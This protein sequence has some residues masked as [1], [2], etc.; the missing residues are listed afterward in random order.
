MCAFHCQFS[1]PKILWS[2]NVPI[3]K[4]HSAYFLEASDFEY[5]Y[6]LLPSNYFSS[7]STYLS[8]ICSFCNAHFLKIPRILWHSNAKQSS[9]FHTTT[10]PFSILF[11]ETYTFIKEIVLICFNQC[12]IVCLITIIFMLLLIALEL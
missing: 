9:L 6:Q 8:K 10:S 7:R 3:A 12:T 11:C 5:Y 4:Q 1:H 2:N